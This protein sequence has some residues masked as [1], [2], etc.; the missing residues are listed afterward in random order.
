MVEAHVVAGGLAHEGLAVLGADDIGKGSAFGELQHIGLAVHFII[1]GR[2]VG[3]L[4]TADLQPAVFHPVC[5]R[6][7]R[8]AVAGEPVLVAAGIAEIR[9][10]GVGARA[11][12][13]LLEGLGVQQADIGIHF[14]QGSHE[15]L[16]FFHGGTVAFHKFP[17]ASGRKWEAP[18]ARIRRIKFSVRFR[19][20]RLCIIVKDRNEKEK[21]KHGN[22]L[23]FVGFT[24]NRFRLLCNNFLRG[25]GKM[26]KR[27]Q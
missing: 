21:G 9:P 5:Q 1:P 15:L 18:D 27:L 6:L 23:D 25:G 24:R 3:C 26:G 19:K 13:Y 8:G 14:A 17:N 12:L 7:L 11:L 16:H 22:C 4:I 2:D 20:T 10:M